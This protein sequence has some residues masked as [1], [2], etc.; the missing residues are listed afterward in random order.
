MRFA[1][2]KE[3][4]EAPL[5]V[6]PSGQPYVRN[7]LSLAQSALER[8]AFEGVDLAMPQ[9]VSQGHR[10]IDAV[11]EGVRLAHG[12]TWT[13]TVCLMWRLLRRSPGYKTSPLRPR[14]ACTW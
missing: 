11:R 13:G 12:A 4:A 10:W 7:E 6:V 1:R 2:L 8:L 9:R 14:S 3:L 5:L